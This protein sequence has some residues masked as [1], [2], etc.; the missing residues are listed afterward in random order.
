VFADTHYE[1]FIKNLKPEYMKKHSQVLSE[2]VNVLLCFTTLMMVNSSILKAQSFKLF[3]V[4][5]LVRV[6]ED[7]YNMPATQDTIKVFGIRGEIISGQFTLNARKNLSNVTVEI[8]ALKNNAGGNDL[9]PDA[10]EWNFVGSIPLVK[11]SPNQPLTAL[12]RQAPAR[13]PEYLM[14]EKELNIKDKTWQSVWLTIRIPESV[15][16]GTYYG[17]VTVKNGQEVQSLP[18]VVTVYPLSIPSERHLKVVEW[19]NTSG[20]SRFHDIKEVYSP[21]WFSM[22]RKYADNM[23]EHRQNTFRVDMNVIDIQQSKDGIFAFDFSLFDQIAQVFWNTGK[24]DYME[25]GFLALRG[26]KG[27]SD[28]NFRWREFIINKTETGEKITLPGKDVIPYLVSAFEAH[29]RQKGWLNKTWFHIQDE[30]AVHNAQSWIEFS[31]FIHQYG[32]D[33]I[34]MDAIETTY[35]LDDIEIAVPKLDHFATWN[36]TYKKWQQKG[37]ELWFYTVGIY[38][39]SLF[40]NKTIDVPVMD[41]RILHWMN[42]KYDAPGFLHWG[43]NQWN[44]TP[45]QDVGMHIGDGWH[46]YPAKDGVLNSLRWEQMRNGIQDYEYFWMLESKIK[47]LKDSLGSRF[48]W[49]DP[50]QRGKEISGNVIKGFADYTDDPQVLYKEKMVIIKDLME[51][52]TS[53]GLYVQTNPVENSDVTSRSSVEVFGWTEPGTKIIVNG[54]DLPVSNQGLFVE[55]FSLSAKGNFIRVQAS[56]KKGSKEIVRH[57]VVK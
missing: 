26:E 6:F 49:I 11:N 24:M 4:S 45:F 38:Q 55:Q 5:D 30:P 37:N 57:F 19:Y 23:T 33:L 8:S 31:R 3:G 46:V 22:L 20:F 35:L 56:G 25:T 36:E 51:F 2:F 10:T 13:F 48:T 34:R 32:P 9:P 15:S 12:T 16:A 18:L 7:G 52:D 44:E 40:P 29:L 53:P 42:Y 54:Q 39:G 1:K 50:K 28:S 43:W 21:E 41:S 14:S 27:W 17:K 47:A